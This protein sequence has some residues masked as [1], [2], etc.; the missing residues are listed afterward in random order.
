M[1]RIEVIIVD[2]SVGIPVGP[3]VAIGINVG[4]S[5]GSSVVKD[6]DCTMKQN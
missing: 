2:P 6:G 5:V 3:C 1:G 4:L